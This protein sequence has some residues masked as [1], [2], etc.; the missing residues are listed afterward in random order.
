MRLVGVRR[1]SFLGCLV[2]WKA[3]FT[4]S[5][6]ADSWLVCDCSY[7]AVGCIGSVGEDRPSKG[8]VRCIR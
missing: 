3:A 6:R 2:R 5:I 8:L 1:E 7:M 4:G